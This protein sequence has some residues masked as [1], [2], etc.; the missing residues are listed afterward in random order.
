MISEREEGF[1][2]VRRPAFSPSPAPQQ[3]PCDY[4]GYG[5]FRLS[6][7]AVVHE[8]GKKTDCFA[9]AEPAAQQAEATRLYQEACR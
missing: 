1:V 8:D 5:L 4:A 2:E 3:Q 7:V 9:F 6:P